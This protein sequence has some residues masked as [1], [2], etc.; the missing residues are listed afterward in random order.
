MLASR[1]DAR[2]DFAIESIE[3]ANALV[4]ARTLNIALSNLVQTCRPTNILGSSKYMK[5]LEKKK[6]EAEFEAEL[7][8]LAVNESSLSSP[9]GSTHYWILVLRKYYSHFFELKPTRKKVTFAR[10]KRKA[11]FAVGNDFADE[12][13][14]TSLRGWVYL[15][16]IRGGVA[17]NFVLRRLPYWDILKAVAKKNPL[18]SERYLGSVL[19][20]VCGS[21]S[22]TCIH[23][24]DTHLFLANRK[25]MFQGQSLRVAKPVIDMVILKLGDAMV[26]N[27]KEDL[28]EMLA[29]HYAKHENLKK[30][31]SVIK[32]ASVGLAN[33]VAHQRLNASLRKKLLAT[34]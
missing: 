8:E 24:V 12:L 5:I 3:V 27:P 30:L 18:A 15:A 23:A 11:Y 26:V 20:A 19:K 13:P 4:L 25:L 1:K 29:T 14:P 17:D 33:F 6:P 28:L 34:P 7:L 21:A 9:A 10:G 16:S 31:V 32:T 22:A 2:R